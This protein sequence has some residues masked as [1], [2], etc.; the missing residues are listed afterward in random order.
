[1]FKISLSIKTF[2]YRKV[3]VS[4][5]F[6]TFRDNG[7]RDLCD[8]PGIGRMVKSRMPRWAGHIDTTRDKKLIQ[9][10]VG[11][12]PGKLP[13]GRPRGGSNDTAV[14]DFRKQSCG[15]RRQMELS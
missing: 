14:I 7:F 2:E 10:F 3:K 11:K 4:E 13:R 5:K 6:R 15:G 8:S 1:M 9:N 12:P